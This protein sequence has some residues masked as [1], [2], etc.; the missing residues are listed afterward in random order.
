MNKELEF[1]LS[2][3]EDN[4]SKKCERL[5]R[6]FQERIRDLTASLSKSFSHANK[7][8]LLRQLGNDRTSAGFMTQRITEI[9]QKIIKA[10]QEAKLQDEM[11][12]ISQRDSDQVMAMRQRHQEVLETLNQRIKHIEEWNTE[13]QKEVRQTSE[14]YGNCEAE[15]RKLLEKE[16]E[17]ERMRDLVH[18][19]AER[20]VK[21]LRSRLKNSEGRTRQLETSLETA[22]LESRHCMVKTTRLS[23]LLVKSESERLMIKREYTDCQNQATNTLKENQLQKDQIK[24]DINIFDEKVKELEEK[25]HERDKSNKSHSKALEELKIEL[26]E[27]KEVSK[28]SV[29]MVNKLNARIASLQKEL[30]ASKAKIVTEVNAEVQAEQRRLH[31]H[32]QSIVHKRLGEMY[33]NQQYYCDLK[34]KEMA[35]RHR[36]NDLGEENRAFQEKNGELKKDNEDLKK[37]NRELKNKLDEVTQKLSDLKASSFLTEERTVLQT[38]ILRLE[39]LVQSKEAQR[40]ALK[41]QF[42]DEQYSHTLKYKSK[43]EEVNRYKNLLL[44]KQENFKREV[45]ELRSSLREAER[46]SE[47]DGGEFKERIHGLRSQLKIAPS[48]EMLLDSQNEISMKSEE[49]LKL[50][51]DVSKLT[52][53]LNKVRLNHSAMNQEIEKSNASF[54]NMTLKLR[55]KTRER[56]ACRLKLLQTKNGLLGIKQ[57]QVHLWNVVKRIKTNFAEKVKE[58]FRAISSSTSLMARAHQRNM[59]PLQAQI[60][61]L[62]LENKELLAKNTKLKGNAQNL[63]KQADT[64]MEIL[65]FQAPADC[66]QNEPLKLARLIEEHAQNRMRKIEDSL[67]QRTAVKV[68][69]LDNKIEDLK[70]ENTLALEMIKAKLRSQHAQ[71]MERLETEMTENAE[72]YACQ[73]EIERKEFETQL[74]QKVKE[75]GALRHLLSTQAEA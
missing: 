8:V 65:P 70:T 27:E 23:E 50:K 21:D 38:D 61:G 47:R 40:A 35:A 39:G 56:E 4:Y 60:N 5:R 11:E 42:E 30:L 24:R 17:K 64:F 10:D 57:Q 36:Q 71:K 13:L 74:R 7:D 68:R 25:I 72:G 18:D 49:I 6:V 69:Q 20:E 12:K 54:K 9:V 32:Y 67:K 59:K 3:I 19:S 22:K 26:K 31:E 63:K 58:L 43:Y 29:E 52:T 48:N 66:L 34:E 53:A 14:D 44:E 45:K 16:S 55:R 15:R 73:I 1:R 28:K 46:K 41:E 75:C 37:N 2:E 51:N 33:K 62:R